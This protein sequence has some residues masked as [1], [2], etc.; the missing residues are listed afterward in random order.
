MSLRNVIRRIG[1]A[2]A[3]TALVAV[4]VALAT[5]SPASA[6]TIPYGNLQF[7]AQG[8]YPA[9]VHVLREPIGFGGGTSPETISTIVFPGQCW[10]NPVSTAGVWAQVDIVGLRS[11]GSEFWVGNSWYNS[12]VSGIGLGAEGSEW[13]HWY[14]QW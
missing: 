10:M 3:A 13:N 9:Y 2:L 4:P 6:S 1:V 11:N 12:S 7:C 5:S 14:W 8:S